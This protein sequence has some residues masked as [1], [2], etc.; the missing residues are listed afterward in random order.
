[1]TA[2]QNLNLTANA[3]RQAV[4]ERQYDNVP[5]LLETYTRATAKT[6][7]PEALIEARELMEWARRLILARRAALAARLAEL[8]SRPRAYANVTDRVRP[9][10]TWEVRG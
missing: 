1:M 10:H 9:R 8:V 5:Q 6:N 4:C 3:V 7:A 2:D